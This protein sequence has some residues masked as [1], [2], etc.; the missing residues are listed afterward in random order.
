MK[1]RFLLPIFLCLIILSACDNHPQGKPGIQQFYILKFK[2]PVYKDYILTNNHGTFFA[3]TPYKDG[4]PNGCWETM[5]GRNP[6]I[7]LSDDY[8]LVDW[9]WA[10]NWN[11]EVVVFIPWQE[12]ISWTQHWDTAV[13]HV[14]NPISTMY[15]C[16]VQK[17]DEE[18]G[19][20]FQGRLRYYPYIT[21]Y[22]SSDR[23][24][25]SSSDLTYEV[26]TQDLTKGMS[27]EE[28]EA[29]YDAVYEQ[30]ARQLDSLISIGEF[31]LDCFERCEYQ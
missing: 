26:L 27:L 31:P 5:Q 1:I 21:N 9:R 25:M 17:F 15:E 6:Y 29:Y 12:R 7:S 22:F 11:N 4:V 3:S 16:T 8:V 18:M 20:V 13:A 19:N 28:V 14:N 10:I 24:R 30:L 23:S 2:D